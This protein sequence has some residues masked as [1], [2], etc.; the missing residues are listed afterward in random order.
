MKI[1]SGIEVTEI[2]WCDVNLT[3]LSWENDGRDL[4]LKWNLHNKQ[5]G[6]LKCLWAS[7][8]NISLKTVKN[9]GG[10]PLTFDANFQQQ[11]QGWDVIFNFGSRGTIEFMCNE[12]MLETENS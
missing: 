1:L 7:S 11:T 12:L 5:K 6:V 9:E 8:I 4:I 3:V 10:L 2:S